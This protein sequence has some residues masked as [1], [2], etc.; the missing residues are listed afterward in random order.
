MVSFADHATLNRS[1]TRDAEGVAQA[2]A[3]FRAYG[4]TALYDAVYWSVKQ[5]AL[6]PRT[7]GS[8]V[9]A[10][11]RSEA[12]RVVL[13]LT[14]GND[15]RSQT[16]PEQV[17]RL[18]RANG[19]TIYTIGLGSD[20]RADALVRLARMTG[21]R[22]FQAPG[23]EALAQLYALI[24]RQLHS[25][26]GLRYRSPNPSRDGT[27][28]EVSVRLRAAEGALNA[29][30]WYQ[31]PGAGSSVI[32]LGPPPAAGSTTATLP[33]EPLAPDGG[34]PASLPI[35]LLRLLA[36][37]ALLAA[38]A[39][40][41]FVS[42]SRIRRGSRISASK[43]LATEA[44]EGTERGFDGEPLDS[45][46]PAEAFF[47]PSLSVPSVAS[48]AK[49]SG[50]GVS[51]GLELRPLWVRAPATGVG[52]AEENDLVLDSPRVS[53]HHARIEVTD[54]EYRLVDNGSSNGTFLNGE[55]VTAAPISVGD[56]IRFADQEFRFA[57][58][59]GT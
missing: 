13:A 41:F 9:T 51:P 26:Y 38:V 50:S 18:A 54:G 40:A 31:A 7:R 53:R 27:R 1:L 11:G 29:Q 20:V 43:S 30:G 59:E 42:R 34:P 4:G 15:N 10:A 3:A 12:R 46:R 57:G 39:A 16:S 2:A 33:G 49:S 5:V 36:G 24:V 48:V 25:E 23:P 58:E 22:Y 55:R 35:T 44:T 28:R 8:L 47:S 56:V 52:R 14:D 21:G 6:D 19:I 45:S 37:A 17:V 32:A